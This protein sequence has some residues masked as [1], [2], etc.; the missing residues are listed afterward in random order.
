MPNGVEA[1]LTM[2]K[3]YSSRYLF[4]PG[5]NSASTPRLSY[6][7][8]SHRCTLG[9]SVSVGRV[10][11]LDSP[12]NLDHAKSLVL[13]TRGPMSIGK[14]ADEAMALANGNAGSGVWLS[15]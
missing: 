7:P 15:V 4:P 8:P 11:C 2:R 6:T 5:L 3:L 13:N 10:A 9:T 14:A 12:V 1:S